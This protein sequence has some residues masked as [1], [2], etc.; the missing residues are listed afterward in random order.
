MELDVPLK[1]SKFINII[2]SISTV[3]TRSFTEHLK[4]ST[5][6]VLNSLKSLSIGNKYFQ[7]AISILEIDQSML[8]LA[9]TVI[10]I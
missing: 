3:A 10:F 6:S 5:L 8:L 4:I 2:D 1:T 7:K 9:L